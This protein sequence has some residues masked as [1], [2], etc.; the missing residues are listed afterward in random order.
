MKLPKDMPVS[1]RCSWQESSKFLASRVRLMWDF[2]VFWFLGFLLPL[3]PPTNKMPSMAIP[4][5]LETKEH[6]E[7]LRLVSR[8]PSQCGCPGH[9][10]TMSSGMPP[11]SMDPRLPPWPVFLISQEAK[12]VTA[13]G[14]GFVSPI[15]SFSEIFILYNI[16]LYIYSIYVISKINLRSYNTQ[17]L[18][19]EVQ[20]H[21]QHYTKKCCFMCPIEA[22][23]CGRGKE[24]IKTNSLFTAL[25][26]CKRGASWAKIRTLTYHD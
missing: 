5:H 21:W 22:F 26:F 7:H 18:F 25:S 23:L 19:I 1:T 12:G 15:W 9:L 16:I 13:T 8:T 10:K 11:F 20:N 6:Q 2:F 14:L 3:S 24:A 4:T 17:L